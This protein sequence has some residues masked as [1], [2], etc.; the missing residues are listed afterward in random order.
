MNLFYVVEYYSE[1]FFVTAGTA[2]ALAIATC[3]IFCFP[4]DES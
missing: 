4:K 2:T 1:I 3:L